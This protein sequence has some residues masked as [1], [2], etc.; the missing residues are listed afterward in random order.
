MIRRLRIASEHG[1]D[2][3]NRVPGNMRG[4]QDLRQQDLRPHSSKPAI[5]E[6]GPWPG[7]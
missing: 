6:N 4:Q 5:Q 7:T 1:Q 2:G 3:G